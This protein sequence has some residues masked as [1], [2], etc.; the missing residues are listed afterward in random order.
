MKRIQKMIDSDID[1]QNLGV[2]NFKIARLALIDYHK[3]MQGPEI[4]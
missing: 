2:C 3:Y 1:Q 4:N